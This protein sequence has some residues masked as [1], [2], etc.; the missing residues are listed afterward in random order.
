MAVLAPNPHFFEKKFFI[1]SVQISGS[2]LA[3]VGG[4]FAPPPVATLMT[5]VVFSVFVQWRSYVFTVS[6]L[7][8]V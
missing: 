8:S 3:V 2:G 4:P 5:Q 6:F 7:L 1:G